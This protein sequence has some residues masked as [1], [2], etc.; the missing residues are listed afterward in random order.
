V[1]EVL[2]S[3]VAFQKDV[4]DRHGHWFLLRISP[5]R[6]KGQI[7]GV[8]I[9]LVDIAALKQTEA[10]LKRMS[11][12]FMDVADPIII[13]DLSGRIVDLNRAA[14]EAYG[15]S[16]EELIGEN[17]NLLVP[18]EHRAQAAEFRERC[19]NM[20][21]VRNVE[22]MRQDKA[23]EIRPVLLTLSL[24]GNEEGKPIGIATLAKDISTQKDAEK[25]ARE[26]VIRR[27]EFLAM[28]SHELRNP[29]GAVLN[30]AQLMLH[31][32]AK[33]EANKVASQ[34][35]V[36]QGQQM[37][38]LLDDLLDV[39]RV[40]QGKIDIR[41]Q[42]VDLNELVRNAVEAVR[43][44]FTQRRHKLDVRVADGPLYVEGDS[45][46]LLQIQEN[47]LVNAAKYTPAEGQV[48]I[49]LT[50]DGDDAVNS[51]EDN[52]QGI[53]VD[54]LSAIFELF[55]QEK[56]SL[57]RTEGGMG[58]GLS[59]VKLLVELHG[60]SV[61]VKSD[62]LGQGSTFTVRVPLTNKRPDA[63]PAVFVSKTTDTKVL[64]VEDNADSRATLEHLLRFDGYQ[65]SSASDGILGYEA[66]HREQP[67][68]ALLDIGL[69]GMSGYELA[70]RIRAA[71]ADGRIRLV[72]L[73]GYGRG[74]DHTSVM[75][76]GFDEHLIKPVSR[77]DLL[78]VL[79]KAN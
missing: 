72:A 55:V 65:V 8:V 61:C 57:A 19:R 28:L 11:K 33:P 20:E 54:M 32:E 75:E 74:E 12:V 68:I 46:R 22:T 58:I 48:A 5:Y 59:L 30:A 53:P 14:A 50:R 76:A 39:S 23:G 25:A 17:V 1:Q 43:P 29:L 37:A 24:L 56:K 38:R 77:D 6:S 79:R 3:G 18:E 51:V 2:E 10:E 49:S 4:Q 9:T 15:W 36:R 27:D 67:D 64:I 73:P 31:D 16:R 34:V 47:L 40:T 63:A 66:I 71:F 26:A 42:A 21:H 62:G 44:E 60:G 45:A 13:E 70:R 69:P 7:D 52:G 78:R 35:I 41:K